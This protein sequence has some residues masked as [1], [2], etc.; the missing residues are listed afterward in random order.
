MR[1]S[2]IAS[3]CFA[4]SLSA[5]GDLEKDGEGSGA[6]VP[7]NVQVIFTGEC[8]KSG[9][10]VGSSPEA[11]MNLSE[12]YAYDEIVNVN[13]SEQSVLKRVL[14]FE[15]DNSYLV[16]KI[17]GTAGIDGGQ[18]PDDGPPYLTTAQIDTIRL[19]ITNGAQAR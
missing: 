6:L 2:M 10:H 14:P 5:C 15:P 7:V 3:V 9:C 19:W 1:F 8:A 12:V 4:F 16:R 17:Q 13:S 11:G 18:M